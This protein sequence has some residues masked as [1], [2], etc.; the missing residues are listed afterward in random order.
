MYDALYACA[1]SFK[2]NLNNE[3]SPVDLVGIA[4]IAAEDAARKTRLIQNVHPDPGA[5][6][7]GIWMRAVYEALKLQSWPLV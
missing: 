7:V 2:E 1:E 6:A 4:T 5:H 3:L